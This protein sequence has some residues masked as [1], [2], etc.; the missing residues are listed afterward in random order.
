MKEIMMTKNIYFLSIMMVFCWSL[1][2]AGGRKENESRN[3]ED[4]AGFTDSID[5][6]KKPSG[7]YNYY[8]EAKDK[9]GNISLSGPENI[10]N[11]PET[12]LPRATII[13]PVLNMR[14]QGNL[15]IVGIA[16]DD[17]GIDFVDIVITRGWDGK[18]EELVRTRAD[19]KE[20]WSYFLDTT[21]GDIWTDGIYT[22]TVWA[23][24]INGLSGI[25]SEYPNGASVPVKV[26]KKHQVYWN[27]DRKKPD[28][29][30]V[31]HEVGALVAGKI[32]LKGTVT[33]GN[34]INTFSY[35]ID[36]GK[37]YLPVKAGFD[38]KTGSYNWDVDINTK[39]F[40]DG[41]AIIW[42]QARD[43][44]NTLGSAAHLLFANNTGPEIKIVYPP[45]DTAVNGIFSI[46]GYA[47]HPVGLNSITWKA[48]KASGEFPIVIGNHWW[49]TEIDLRG[50]K[51]SSVEIEIRAEDVS[52]NVTVSKQK[53]KVDQNADLP[54]ISMYEPSTGDVLKSKD[55]VVRGLVKD[56][57]GAASLFYSLDA[58]TAVEIPCSGLFQFII[59]GLS[60][61]IHN[62][63][64][65]AKDITGVT[66]NKVQIKNLTVPAALPVPGI[67]SFS[68]GSGKTLVV[69]P[70]YTGMT[71]TPEPKM[72]MEFTAKAAVVASAS[73]KFGDLPAIPVKT[74]AGKDGI[75]RGNVTVPVNLSGGFTKI[76]LR[77]ADRSGREGYFEE[78]IFV[79]DRYGYQFDWIRP[80]KTDDGRILLGDSEETLLGF[81]AERLEQ[82]E[83]RGTGAQNLY[84]EVDNF[85]RAVLMAQK[86][87]SYGPL[88]L[89]MLDENNQTRESSPFRILADFSPPVVSMRN[90]PEGNWVQDSVQVSFN[91]SSR[92]RVASVEYSSN[93][94]ALWQPL[95]SNA[96]I[97]ALGAEVNTDI[98]RTLNIGD[99]EDGSVNV[100]IR[101]VSEA[102]RTGT[103]DFTVLKDTQA[104]LA[105]L[106]IP[107]FEARVNGTIL[108]GFSVQETGKL[109]SVA[110]S[111]PASTG[112]PAI[113]KQVYN[114]NEW[115]KNYQ[116]LFLPVMM[117]SI[118]MPLDEKMVFTFE[119]MAGNK[120][121]IKDWHFIIDAESD[122]PIVEIVLPFEN[123]VITTDFAVSG[124]MFDDDEIKQIYWKLDNGPE[125]IVTAKNGFFIPISLSDMT[126]NEHSVTVV[127][128]DIYGV[129]SA[130]V[131]RGFR[132][133]LSE[134]SAAVT[135]PSFTDILR[136]VIKITG[137]S[138]DR[139]GIEKVEVSLDNGNTYNNA[140][141]TN[142]WGYQFNTKI[143]KDG[144]HVVF[145]RVT[146]KY[147]ISATYSSLINVDNTQPVVTLDSP[148]DGSITTGLIGIMGRADDPNLEEVSI[149][150][151]SL[152]GAIVSSELRSR[153]LDNNSIIK[154]SLDL[155]SQQDGLY[156]IEIVATDKAKNVTRISRNVKLAR[157]SMKNF[158]EILYP[159]ENENVQGV[160]NLYGYAGGTDKPETVTIRI[161][162]SDQITNEIEKS[163]YFRFSL[164]PE[165]FDNTSGEY[166]IIVYSNFGGNT[167]VMSREQNIVY[168]TDG[169]WVTIDSFNIG[170]FAYERPY[171]TGRSGYIRS[172][173][174]ELMLNDKAVDKETK[175]A[176]K[177]MVPNITEL[178]FDNGKT[179][180]RTS[181]S[182]K[183]GVQNYKYRLETGDMYEGVHYILVRSTMKNGETA[184]TRVLVQVDKTP[185]QIKLITPEPGGR[186][187]TEIVYSASAT[188]DVD[189][190]ELNYYLRKGDKSSYEIPGFL[191]GLYFEGI[192]PPFIKQIFNDAPNIFSGGATYFDVGMGLSFFG[193]NVKLQIQYGRMTQSLFESLGGQGQVRYGGDVLG[194]KLLANIYT[195]PFGSFAG[196]DWEW[197]FASFS[198]GANFSLFDI[199][200][201]GYTQSGK[202]TW[203][204]ALL[205]QLEFPKITIPKQRFL[206]TFSLFT[207]GQLWFVPTDVDADKMGIETI[208]P[209]IVI[210]LRVYIF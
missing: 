195:L 156:N 75:F 164:E 15:N 135:F 179:F 143:L 175:N 52:G 53:Y 22:I 85:G 90:T 196:P 73:V 194:L 26:H 71:I 108:I 76:E 70:F 7:K 180:I 177:D 137:T 33:D 131:T 165:H 189:L 118:E 129:K 27:L 173:D 109:K 121:E 55:L 50:E 23:T 107:I 115:D 4:P 92:N 44:Q 178:S 34:G 188:D 205:I 184:V 63:D 138:F 122:I 45:V 87:G 14:V 24:D 111:R 140:F 59:P 117:D 97:S 93:M 13:N 207:E 62:L 36:G 114:V 185:P 77:A 91:V 190:V 162:G 32:R 67:T 100:L 38:K 105:S 141:G 49:S 123:E 46:A 106:I 17:D 39:L 18:G 168:K 101:A 58:G 192:I 126:D 144:A 201:Q 172:E 72:I 10:Y 1:L 65:W 158:V 29:R 5:I 191:Q 42:F 152:E 51:T 99:A 95:L 127:A 112:V 47:K 37:R 60:E 82:V 200:Q 41:P 120:S 204:S 40:E 64:I 69:S 133:S 169:P 206:R 170:D 203:M 103:A 209:H 61:G 79:S 176:I 110:Y 163:G 183:K 181:A 153:K 56:D 130:P 102:G 161:N 157:A 125:R 210:G 2:W 155:S 139:N 193:D 94:G 134:P 80:N 167:P 146:D 54:V 186:Y 28:I 98:T 116:I 84:V 8:L 3:A 160:F 182:M 113:T 199:R 83:L 81:G 11:D 119:D 21:N 208:I 43:G 57:D 89:Y 104:P 12:D 124:V 25:A 30:V 96:E 149:E 148:G 19:G 198:V 187:N 171:F 78:Y 86:E 150:L 147:G 6:S 132:I 128:E 151:R 174:N 166:K 136:D 202:S 88:T 154:E 142:E 31:S 9:A 20:Y 145:V 197:L 74:S 16:M 66:G 68:T 159:L 35:S 48:G